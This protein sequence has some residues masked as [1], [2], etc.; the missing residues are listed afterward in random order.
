M[1][2]PVAFTIPIINISI[3]WYGIIMITGI[4]V[5]AWITV[6]G[7]QRK[8]ENPDHVWDALVWAIPAGIIGARLWYVVNDI[9]GGGSHYLEH[10]ISI[11]NIPEGGLH[12][13]GA[14]LFGGVAAYAY[15]RRHKLDMR[16]F[17]DSVALALLISQALIRPANYI[18][19]EL[20]GPPTDLPWGIPIDA[21]F[22]RPPWNDLSL[23][24]VETTRFHPAFA[25]EMVW[26]F[27]AAGLLFW[28]SRRFS[29]KLR[30]GAQF[31]GWLIL[32]G[33]GRVILEWFRPDQPRVPGT[34]ISYTRI[35]AALMALVGVVW[36]LVRYDVL[37]LP[38]L[39]PGSTSYRIAPSEPADSDSPEEPV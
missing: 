30:P 4:L 25:Y 16:L 10:P 13:Y 29:D 37:R 39:S 7:V 21:P 38:F 34:D 27:A 33:V 17:L 15:V 12:Y 1:I 26:N 8:G 19:Q 20:Y 24:P 18:N 6:R 23:Y 14:L 28:V 3:R 22:R 32:A 31:A 11:I 9:L 2:D 36:L 5:G 35:V